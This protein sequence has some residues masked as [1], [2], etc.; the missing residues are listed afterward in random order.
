MKKLFLLPLLMVTLVG[1]GCMPGPDEGTPPVTRT[2]ADFDAQ[3][4]KIKADP[5]MTEQAKQGAIQGI[6]M[7]K[8]MATANRDA[9]NA[10]AKAMQEA[11]GKGPG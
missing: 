5:N 7:S 10:S 9:E 4:E 3:I 2:A 11:K 6:E 8:R 1:P